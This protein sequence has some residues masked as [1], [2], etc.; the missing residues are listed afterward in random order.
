MVVLYSEKFDEIILVKE[1]DF[2]TDNSILGYA[3]E[4]FTAYMEAH[5]ELSLYLDSDWYFIGFL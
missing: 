2:R 3:S 4:L 1:D 5:P